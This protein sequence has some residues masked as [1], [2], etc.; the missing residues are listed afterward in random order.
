MIQLLIS[1]SLRLILN[2]IFLELDCCTDMFNLNK[3]GRD[4]LYVHILRVNMHKFCI[5]YS[6][7]YLNVEIVLET[8]AL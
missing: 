2:N 8:Y 1:L 7:R 6:V 3:E 4:P 5:Q